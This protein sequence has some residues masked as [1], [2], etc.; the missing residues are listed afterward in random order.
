M[1]E[2]K[3]LTRT[4]RPTGR[5]FSKWEIER[6]IFRLMKGF[7]FITRV[8]KSRRRICV[9]MSQIRENTGYSNKIFDRKPHRK[10]I[11]GSHK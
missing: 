11:L 5:K 6:K 8:N 7:S 9:G 10:Q 2:N 4:V 1:L 3:A